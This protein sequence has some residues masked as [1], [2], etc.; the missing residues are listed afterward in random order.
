[1]ESIAWRS[2]NSGFAV[3]GQRHES[4]FQQIWYIPYPASRN[5]VRRIGND[6][7]DYI[8]A[9]LT[10]SGSEIVSVQFQTLSNIYVAKADNPSRAVQVTPG[11]GRYFDLAW[12]PDGR[13]LYASD[14]TGSADLWIMNAD[15][16]G[17]RQI[18]SHAGRNYAPVASPDSRS[19]AFH[20]N[21]TGNWQ[22]WRT[23]MDG[24]EPK[25]LSN[26]AG[27]GNWPQFTA[28]GRTVLFHKTNL[29]GVFNLWQ[30][31][32]EGGNAQQITTGLTMHPAVSPWTGE[33]AAWYS[34]TQDTPNWKIAIFAR[35]GGDPLRVLNPP[36]NARPDTAIRWMPKGDA[37]AVLDYTNSASNIYAI[38]LDGSSPRALTS[39]D[40][41]EI[42]SFDWSLDGRLLYS[43]GLSTSDVVL[44]HD[45]NSA[46][47]NHE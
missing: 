17:Q 44:I 22:V 13:I 35:T 26:S 39:F 16:T 40:S 32:V 20:S 25:Q 45:L 27:D 34:D 18:T 38:P 2:D 9:S 43:R 4:S 42:F 11:S 30:V 21:R 7:D 33:I 3:V 37:V 24:T 28:G 41:G 12:A 31:P 36:P 1:V 14:A 46:E 23:N 29:N 19:V 5:G 15:G 10:A 47:G 6:L 8:G